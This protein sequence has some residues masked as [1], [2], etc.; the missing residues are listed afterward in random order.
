[1][2]VRVPRNAE[3][4]QAAG[5]NGLADFGDDV[6]D[7]ERGDFFE[8]ADA[9]MTA[10]GGDDDAFGTGGDEAVREAGVDGD[11]GRDVI[12]EEMTKQGRGVGVDDG[13]I[14]FCLLRGQ[15]G[16]DPA[17]VEVCRGGSDSA[18]EPDVH[19]LY[20]ALL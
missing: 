13:E 7:G 6:D 1:M 17:V 20:S 8:G 12:L 18:D 2:A 10:D 11:L 19:V 3:S 9:E 4:L 16:D 5:G 14:E 15:G